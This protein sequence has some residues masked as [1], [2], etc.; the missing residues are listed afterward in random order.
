MYASSRRTKNPVPRS[1]Y[2]TSSSLMDEQF[3]FRLIGRRV[4]ARAGLTADLKGNG[5]LPRTCEPATLVA[6]D[7]RSC[8]AA[9]PRPCEV[10]Q[11]EA[12]DLGGRS[13][14]A[15]EVEPSPTRHSRER[16][17]R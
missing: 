16:D 12:A 2:D 7:D 11:H 1:M 17:C 13:G 8:R 10:P 9:N 15:H 6:G 5:E 3:P 14:F 4:P